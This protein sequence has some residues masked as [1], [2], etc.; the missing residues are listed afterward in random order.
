MRHHLQRLAQR[1]I[2]LKNLA[3]G[4]LR[5]KPEAASSLGAS[6]HY[7][8]IVRDKSLAIAYINK[9]KRLHS[10]RL[11]LQFSRPC[12]GFIIM[13]VGCY[14]FWCRIGL[15]KRPRRGFNMRHDSNIRRAQGFGERQAVVKPC[16]IF[17]LMYFRCLPPPAQF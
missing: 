6:V 12:R 17:F 16:L 10:Q 8:S 7:Y 15:G 3:P 11:A 13:I 2:A 1:W 5:T 4:S 14:F 9:F